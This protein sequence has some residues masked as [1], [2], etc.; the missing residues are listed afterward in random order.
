MQRKDQLEPTPN[1]TQLPPGRYPKSN[2]NPK[3]A[4]GFIQG[5]RASYD[6]LQVIGKGGTSKVKLIEDRKSH[7]QHALKIIYSQKNKR[8]LI[9]DEEAQEY[10][11][12]EYRI[13]G[14]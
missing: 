7:E 10:Y 5:E 13:L 8:C 1:P 3:L 6:V 4:H 11:A 14:K 2:F 9:T 12:K